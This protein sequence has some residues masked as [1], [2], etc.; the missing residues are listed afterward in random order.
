MS[1]SAMTK[2]ILPVLFAVLVLATTAAAMPT[3]SGSKMA[4]TTTDTDKVLGKIL[5]GKLKARKEAR[6]VRKLLD[7][8]DNEQN[9]QRRD[10]SAQTADEKLK[11][12]KSN[13][14]KTK[15]AIEDLYHR[16][17]D[18]FDLFVSIYTVSFFSYQA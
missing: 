16:V 8:G 6:L 11:L 13:L 15:V 1:F 5:S 3:F 2:Q 10:T 18:T 12:I 9:R 17:K 4:S 7:L 14:Q